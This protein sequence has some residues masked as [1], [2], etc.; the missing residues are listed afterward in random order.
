MAIRSA[1]LRLHIGL[2]RAGSTSLQDALT[3]TR[4]V[5]FLGKA[6]GKTFASDEV[7]H[8]ARHVAPFCDVRG[9]DPEPWR[10][11]FRQL[12]AERGVAVLSDEILSSIGFSPRGA[13]VG[14][15]QIIENF[16]ALLGCRIE[17]FVVLR[18]QLSLLRSYF[19]A[20]SAAGSGLA[21]E[22][23]VALILLR[24]WRWM[25]PVLDFGRLLPALRGV[26]DQVTVAPF[27]LL[28]SDGGCADRFM[29]ALGAD[30]A[31]AALLAT[32]R[33]Q[34]LSS[35]T[36]RR[37]LEN[38]R[39]QGR[40]ASTGWSVRLDERE[41]AGAGCGPA[42]VEVLRRRLKRL[43][44]EPSSSENLRAAPFAIDPDLESV[45]LRFLAGANADLQTLQPDFDWRALGY[46]G[47]GLGAPQSQHS[48][49]SGPQAGSGSAGPSA[50]G[51]SEIS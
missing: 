38:N 28:F 44:G 21:F 42:Q 50:G 40:A 13:G 48:G 15:V 2:P 20:M 11:A 17:V 31:L 46:H 35:D 6:A 29:S 43:L 10:G 12:L 41:F 47:A 14:P 27:E 33:Y 30:D 51:G 4:S 23:F 22:E 16:R 25:A 45:L 39:L 19:G 1:T 34:P 8:F 18:E 24:R 9:I 37:R 36:L 5:V 32:R 26:A 7:M 49:F 3:A